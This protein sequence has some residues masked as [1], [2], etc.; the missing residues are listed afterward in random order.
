M[1]QYS[2]KRR[3]ILQAHQRIVQL[4]K[5][6]A[7]PELSALIKNNP[8]MVR[9]KVRLSYNEYVKLDDGAE[10]LDLSVR[11]NLFGQEYEKYASAAKAFADG[12]G[13][14]LPAIGKHD[15]PNKL[16]YMTFEMEA[17]QEALDKL[18][19]LAAEFKELLAKL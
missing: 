9:Q 1:K 16:G 14:E 18:K 6:L 5:G 7:D 8:S 17:P 4:A 19:P 13:L 11:M 15:N 12:M 2:E 3:T 10:G